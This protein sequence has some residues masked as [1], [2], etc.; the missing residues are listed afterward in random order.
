MRS[1]RKEKAKSPSRSP[2]APTPPTADPTFTTEGL[3]QRRPP[4][5]LPRFDSKLLDS[6]EAESAQ[7]ELASGGTGATAASSSSSSSSSLPR[8]KSDGTQSRSATSSRSV[9]ASSSIADLDRIL[10]KEKDSSVEVDDEGVKAG[11]RGSSKWSMM[12][13]F[14][15]LWIIAVGVFSVWNGIKAAE[16]LDAERVQETEARYAKLER[17]LIRKA[18]TFYLV[19]TTP[20]E[21]F[22]NR[23]FKVIDAYLYHH[24][25]AKMIIYA[26]HLPLDFF[27]SYSSAGYDVSV[28]RLTDSTILEM[29]NHCPGKKWTDELAKW[30]QGRYYYSHITDFIRFCA[31]Y[32]WGGIYSDF[33]ALLLQRIDAHPT[34]IGKDSSG[35]NGSCSWCLPGGDL[36]LAPGVM[37]ASKGHQLPRNALKI[38]F[39]GAYNP[40]IFNSVGPMAVTK[41]YNQNGRGV[42]V[43]ETNALYPFNYMDSWQVLVSRPDAAGA[44]ERLRRRSLS[45]HLYGHKTKHLPMAS[46][47]ILSHVIDHFS[48]LNEPFEGGDSAVSP[49]FELKFPEHI[50][51]SNIMEEIEDIRL[52]ALTDSDITRTAERFV[53]SISAKHGKICIP[54][55]NTTAEQDWEA[56][57]QLSSTTVANM[58]SKLSRLIYRASDLVDGRDTVTLN[59]AAY[60]SANIRAQPLAT[61]SVTIPVYDIPSLVTIIVKTVGRLDKVISLVT[62]ARKYYPS[63]SIIVADDAED[64]IRPEGMSR[65]FYY[66]PIATDAG[67]SA[68]RNRM[69]ERV[70]SEYFLTL[71]DDFI[72]DATSRL[73]TLIHALDSAPTTGTNKKRFD[74]AAGKNPV[75]EGKFGFDYCGMLTIRDK[76]LHL[77]PGTYGSHATCHHVD[78]V[79]N[80]FLGRTSTFKTTIQ[81]DELLKLGEHEDFFLRAK[82][83]GVKTLTCPGVTFTHD[84][85]PHWLKRNKYER[86]RSRVYDFWKLSLRKHGLV[87]MVSFGK[88]M[89][90]LVHPQSPTSLHSTEILS[91]SITLSWTSPAPSFKILFTES[92]QDRWRPVNNGQG[93]D[94][95]QIESAGGPRIVVGGLEPG[96]SY[97][98]R[99]YAGNGFEFEHKG[100]EGVAKTIGVEEEMSK[101]LIQNPSHEH[102]HSHFYS[103]IGATYHVVNMTSH[104]GEFSGRSQILTRSYQASTPTVSRV[105]QVI[106]G[107]KVESAI[108]GSTAMAGDKHGPRTITFSVHSRAE[109]LFGWTSWRAELYVWVDSAENQ[110]SS[111]NTTTSKF[112]DSFPPADRASIHMEA[113]Y[114]NAAAGW[115]VRVLTACLA[116]GVRVRKVMVGG[117]LE[118]WR[119]SV[120]WD[121]WVVAVGVGGDL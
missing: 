109:Q 73:G 87:K 25:D 44:M 79:P 5:A 91:H 29:S 14:V 48:V 4:E 30:K 121:D 80:I 98:F 92:G 55:K 89:M 83:L 28:S 94:Y 97:R 78:F 8:A 3:R 111:N 69:I 60:K 35:A 41:A 47:S 95:N 24:P 86:M 49:P 37:G 26:S 76:T 108:R 10:G 51:V 20:I 34:F 81:W 7:N 61:Q 100:V 23:N 13:A 62:S 59:F 63:I 16:K 33:D 74:I 52:I 107:D 2:P 114:D 70:T 93:E 66:L 116:E 38:G 104:T 71:D 90:D 19:W 39:E 88:V 65:G 9:S 50:A 54:R 1:P 67:L 75:D 96:T 102:G 21:T 105:Y 56:S 64:M 36:Y 72:L 101:N 68:G 42:T 77:E 120:Y 6:K 18:P 27:K 112:Y 40:E 43:L 11:K 103:S 46:D 45:L 117:T 22:T 85:V 115:Q 119:G 110:I 84:Q 17:Q 106:G 58:N 57:L 82:R 12:I 53:V 31:L 118:A 32:Q 99:V 113:K 15:L